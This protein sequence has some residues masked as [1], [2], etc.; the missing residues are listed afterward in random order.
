MLKFPSGVNNMDIVFLVVGL[1]VGFGAAWV[2]RGLKASQG[3]VQPEA[4]AE[5]QNALKVQETQYQEAKQSEARLEE[6]LQSSGEQIEKLEQALQDA[7]EQHEQARRNTETVRDELTRAG[8]E[9]EQLKKTLAEQ[10]TNLKNLQ[11]QFRQ[12]FKVMASELLEDKSQKFTDLNK[13][14]MDQ[15]LKPL[16]ENIET[17]KEKVQ[18]T[19]EKETRERQSLKDELG[20]LHEL[21]QQ[22]SLEANNLTSA[23][24]GQSQ[25]QG[26]WGEMQLEMILEKSGLQKDVHYSVQESFRTEEGKQLRPDVILKMPENK[27][28]VID[29]KVSLTDY[30]RY[31]S[32]DNEE[33]RIQAEKAHLT[34]LRSHIKELDSKRYQDL[35]QLNSVDF[36]LMFVPIESAFSLA[37]QSELS[38][39]T[40]GQ[41]I[42]QEALEKNVVIVTT[43]TLLATLRTVESI[44]RQDNQNRH[45]MEIA[46]KSG[47]MYDK[48]VNF[49]SDLEKV[50]KQLE[51]TQNTYTDAMK[52]L[53]TG[54]GNLVNRAEAI[55]KLGAKAN[56]KL[57]PAILQM[58]GVDE[59]AD[60]IQPND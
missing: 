54:K 21:N 35:Y 44:W 5:L 59:D 46:K 14:N 3:S 25:T 32:A 9:S 31:C 15:I 33:E 52:K 1:V 60:K 10:E 50:G 43:S 40:A 39:K 27:Q 42:Y 4:I 57:S 41:A 38:L 18:E 49:V 45:A 20:R 56:K 47:D 2:I 19:Y 37:V 24:K 55:R 7:T 53:G 29:S 58:S 26:A 12:E 51:T 28:L 13:S 30:E 36:V 8:A 17:F 6:R 23:L 11:E 22:M 16:K 48:F 34:S